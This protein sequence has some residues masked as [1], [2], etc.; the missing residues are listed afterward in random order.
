MLLDFSVALDGSSAHPPLDLGV[1]VHNADELCGLA[2]KSLRGIDCVRSEVSALHE[3]RYAAT[4]KRAALA[5][6]SKA[7]HQVELSCCLWLQLELASRVSST[8]SQRCT[9]GSK[10][11]AS[12][13]RHSAPPRRRQQPGVQ[14]VQGHRL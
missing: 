12:V 14:G 7:S 5:T 10:G 9:E 13:K 2:T 3:N 8:G 11:I 6:R 4:S 1:L